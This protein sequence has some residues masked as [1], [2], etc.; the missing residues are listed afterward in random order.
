MFSPSSSG[1]TLAVFGKMC[2]KET[3]CG[4]GPS[5]RRMSS[6]DIFDSLAGLRTLV[7]GY[8]ATRVDRPDEQRVIRER[9]TNHFLVIPLFFEF[10]LKEPVEYLLDG[11]AVVRNVIL[12]NSDGRT[13]V[14]QF[15]PQAV[16]VLH[17]GKKSR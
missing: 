7:A 10:E 6:L 15:I 14:D 12:G 16:V 2:S 1:M 8:C 5:L 4:A 11:G 17:L 13:L 3:V 9:K